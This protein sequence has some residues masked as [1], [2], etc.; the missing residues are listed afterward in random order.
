ML[1]EA[2]KEN[3]QESPCKRYLKLAEVVVP[4]IDFPG[5]ASAS[6]DINHKI[7]KLIIYSSIPQNS[8]PFLPTSDARVIYPPY[9]R[10]KNRNS[11]LE[12]KR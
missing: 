6:K 5:V 4:V 7:E 3:M 8:H 12:G 9:K 11:H 1:L 2:G 10:R